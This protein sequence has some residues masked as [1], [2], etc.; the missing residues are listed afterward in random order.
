MCDTFRCRDYNGA[1]LKI[2]DEYC[3]N[4]T[5]RMQ[6]QFSEL[7]LLMRLL[8]V[9]STI[10]KQMHPFC[11][12]LSFVVLS[13]HLC[14]AQWLQAKCTFI[15]NVFTIFEFTTPFALTYEERKQSAGSHRQHGTNTRIHLSCKFNNTE[16]QWEW[17]TE[18]EREGVEE[19]ETQWTKRNSVVRFQKHSQHTTTTQKKLCIFASFPHLIR[20][21]V[22]GNTNGKKL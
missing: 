11:L 19:R 17:E 22:V 18:R 15:R 2:D 9:S 10:S 21:N 4:S 13:M 12:S 5:A 6:F 1:Y 16:L 20:L 14:K 7:H 3:T 8:F